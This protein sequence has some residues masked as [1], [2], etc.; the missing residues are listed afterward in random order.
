VV[1]A[2]AQLAAMTQDSGHVRAVGRG[3]AFNLAGAGVSAVFAIVLSIVVARGL[4][5][6]D[7]GMFFAATSFFLIMAA[8]A[9]LGT[10]LGLVYFLS[11]LR[12]LGQTDQVGAVV[13][14]A[15]GPVVVVAVLLGLALA[16]FAQPLADLILGGDP[17]SVPVLRVLAV[18]L[19]VLALS[20]AVL[21]GTRGFG[22]MRPTVLLDR[23]GRPVLQVILAAIVLGAGFGAVAVTA[24]WVLPY[25]ITVVVAGLWLIRLIRRAGH[26]RSGPA[27]LRS[28]FWRFTGPRA[29]TSVV[30]LC[31]QRLDVVL[32]STLRSPAEAATY[33]V[34]SRVVTFGQLTNSALGLA[35]QPRLARLLAAGDRDGANELY[36]TTTAWIILLNGPLYLTVA[37]FSPLLLGVFGQQYVSAWPVTVAL[38]VAAFIG[39][40]V[41]M[42]DVM[43]SMAGRTTW[44]LANG[45]LALVVQVGLDLILIPPYGAFGAAIGWGAAIITANLVPLIQLAKVDKLHPF[46]RGTALAAVVV[47]LTVAIP[48]ALVVI[49]MGQTWLALAVGL[50]LAGGMYAAVAWRLRAT[51]H[52]EALL[53]S[54]RS[55]RRTA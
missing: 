52:I 37:F 16:V 19:P 54:L 39:N 24:S 36:R 43:L 53:A 29:V 49:V 35:A 41:G 5:Q 1:G 20:D 2:H 55:S 13:R 7:T 38:C 33:A 51:L 48:M 10:P 4:S 31:V 26:Q 30:Q 11:R 34:A 46:G 18:L 21:A 28:E 47:T 22:T 12:E 17:R 27:G 40:G 3:G 44:N 6:S 50:V 25:A 42:V 15:L 45:V 23:M 14:T 32:V 9:R 8:I